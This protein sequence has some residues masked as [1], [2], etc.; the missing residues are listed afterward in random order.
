MRVVHLLSQVELTGAEVYAVDLTDELIKRGHSCYIVSDKIH[1]RTKAAFIPLP[2]HNASF[3]RRLRSVVFLRRFIKTNSID[4]IHAHSRAAVRIGFWATRFSRC[5]L[6]STLHGKQ[7]Y[8]YSKKLFNIYGENILAVCENIKKHFIQQFGFHDAQIQIARNFLNTEYIDTLI[9]SPL[10]SNGRPLTISFL[11]RTSGPKG[12]NWANIINSF[13]ESWMKS[14]PNV[15]FQFGGGEVSFFSVATQQNIKRL[16]L[17][18]PNQF[19]FLGKLDNLFHTIAGSDIVFGSGRIAIESLYLQK[20]T[21]AIGEELYLGLITPENFSKCAESNFGDIDY[22]T[23]YS[24]N[25]ETLKSDLEAILSQPE[26]LTTHPI[27]KL[28]DY[29]TG[30]FNRQFEVDQIVDVY[31]W[32]QFKRRVKKNIPILMYHQIVEP[33]FESPH[34]IYVTESRFDEHMSYL[35]DAGFETLTFKDVLDY[36]THPDRLFPKHPVI[37]SFDDGYEN[38]FTKALPI[39]K[40]HGMKAVFYLLTNPHSHNHWDADTKAPQLKLMSPDQRQ[41][42]AQDMEIGSHGFDHKKL[43]QMNWEQAAQEFENSKQTLEKEFGS[44]ILSYAYTYGDRADRDIQ[45]AKRAGYAFAVNT[46][47]GVLHFADNPHNLFRVS[48]FP[49]DTVNDL[50]RKTKPWYRRYYYFKRQE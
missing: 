49:T 17:A 24:V 39:L 43:S 18:Y 22:Q 42:L 33:G 32:A 14:Y 21:L 20:P 11:G 12:L 46:T 35:K 7:H 50:K 47:R 37:I 45:L 8:S 23:K 4:T 13:V 27:D 29:A 10:P 41:T 2:I 9:P 40:K 5:A 34:K 30:Y 36:K 48:I 3:A 19:K 1:K 6:V 28:K 15:V 38:N 31:S 26:Q 25:F 44:P 16:T